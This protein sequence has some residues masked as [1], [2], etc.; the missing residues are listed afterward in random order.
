MKSAREA[1]EFIVAQ[2]VLEAQRENVILTEVER[3]MLY[4]SES[5]WT[6]PDI[7]AVCDEF[8]AECDQDKYERKIARLIGRAYSRACKGDRQAYEKWWA[9][10]RLLGREDHYIVVMIR[11]AGLRPRY[12]QLKLFVTGLAIVALIL[13]GMFVSI[14]YDIHLPKFARRLDLHASLREYMWAF[15][16]C[17]F[18]LYQSLRF[19]IGAK[20]TDDLTSK[21]LRAFARV[22]NRVK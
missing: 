21:A 15:A 1:K 4:F 20:K 10:M 19:V 17:V 13:G 18:I 22:G 9:S 8:D 2:V 6:L 7:A 5:G 11:L 16:V 12:D 3:R 14:K